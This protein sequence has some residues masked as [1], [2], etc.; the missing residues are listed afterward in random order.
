MDFQAIIDGIAGWLAEPDFG[1]VT[2]WLS[3][4][5]PA[6]AL[7]FFLAFNA[8]CFA[9]W[10]WVERRERKELS[11]LY[12]TAIDNTDRLEDQADDL[13]EQLAVMKAEMRR[14]GTCGDAAPKTMAADLTHPPLKA[15]VADVCWNA[16][17]LPADTAAIAAVKELALQHSEALQSVALKAV[18]L[19]ATPMD[20]HDELN[21]VARILAALQGKDVDGTEAT[22]R[23][24][25]E[26][27]GWVLKAAEQA[28]EDQNHQAHTWLHYAAAML[29]SR[30][31][32]DAVASCNGKKE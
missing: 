6:E 9:R 23:E 26:C 19:A 30:A 3:N 2:S 20:A 8:L 28:K 5:H 25:A 22:H 32:A 17:P 7:P 11:R 16:P 13:N 15:G 31:K 14:A 10:W 18:E 24:R 29:S 12:R 21:A 1:A 27:I 4:L